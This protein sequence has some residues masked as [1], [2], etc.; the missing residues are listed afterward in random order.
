V[1]Q[2]CNSLLT[3]ACKGGQVPLQ[4]RPLLVPCGQLARHALPPHGSWSAHRR[5]PARNLPVSA[6]YARLCLD[7]IACRITLEFCNNWLVKWAWL[8]LMCDCVKI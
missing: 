4:L 6:L 3:R 7:L 2:K 5:W 8:D 1:I